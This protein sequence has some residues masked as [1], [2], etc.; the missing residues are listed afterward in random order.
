MQNFLPTY[1]SPTPLAFPWGPASCSLYTG[2]QL[3]VQF[4]LSWF[5]SAAVS[6]FP[7]WDRAIFPSSRH[8]GFLV[9]SIPMS[10]ILRKAYKRLPTRNQYSSTSI[11]NAGLPK[12]FGVLCMG[13][14]ALSFLGFF[15]VFC[16]CCCFGCVVWLVGS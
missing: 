15:C 4:Q 11:N 16:C 1:P 3:K 2:R 6:T 9:S 7:P 13:R 8:S 14:V 10:L 5:P 12:R